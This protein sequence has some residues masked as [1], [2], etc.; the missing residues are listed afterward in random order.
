MLVTLVS[1]KNSPG[2]TTAT[3]AL[4]AEW[5]RPAFVVDADPSGGDMAA[6]LGRGSWPSSSTVMELVIEARHEPVEAVLRRLAVSVDHGPAV[7]AGLGQPGQAAAVPWSRLAAGFRNLGDSDVL[8][9][10]GRYL[11]GDG[12][13]PLLQGSDHVVIVTWSTLPAVRS[14]ARLAALLREEVLPEPTAMWVL[15]VAPGQP[16]SPMDIAAACR[17][18]L[19]GR[20]PFD[21]RA[22]R[23]WTEGY[24]PRPGFRRSA[25]QREAHRLAH[26][27]PSIQVTA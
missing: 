19:L 5:P 13:A 24:E 26:A 1:A 2:V 22:A 6:G 10:G 9:D 11:S 16:Y 3:L 14:T 15:V 4:A 18:P 7:L 27:A 17:T 12:I 20:L 23:V 21:P 8:C 25:L